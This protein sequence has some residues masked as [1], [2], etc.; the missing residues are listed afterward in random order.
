MGKRV[1][2]SALVVITLGSLLHFAWEWSNRSPVV[3][4][5][6][7]INESTWEHLKMAFWPAL[8]LAPVQRALYGRPAGFIVATAIRTLLPPLLIVVLFYG[9]TALLGA[10]YLPLDIGVFAAAV[11]AGEYAGHSVMERRVGRSARTGLLVL[12]AISTAAFAALTF[13]P[14]SFFL[15]EDPQGTA[16]HGSAAPDT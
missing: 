9:Y 15:F 13:R 5:F 16:I 10:N 4:V 14:P 3:A 1:A 7:A 6:A 2:I 8:W 11:I 12:L